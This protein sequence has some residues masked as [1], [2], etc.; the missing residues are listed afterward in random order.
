MFV[1]PSQEVYAGQVVGIAN[2]SDDL[3]VNVCKKK[4]MTAVRSSGH[5]DALRL[6]PP[7]KFSLE[8]AIEFLA[9]DELLEVTPE[10]IRIR[11]KILDHATRM[12]NLM[13]NRNA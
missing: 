11:K 6:V 9:E 12:K 1:D 5:D 7:I 4:H 13:R 10:S 2:K 3:T 8:Q